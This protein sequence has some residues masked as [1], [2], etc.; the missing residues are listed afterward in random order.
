VN[1]YLREVFVVVPPLAFLRRRVNHSL[2]TLLAQ[3]FIMKISIL[4]Y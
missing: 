2:A 1:E 4:I 3:Q